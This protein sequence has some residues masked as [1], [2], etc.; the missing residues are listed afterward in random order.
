MSEAQ[1]P[2]PR[3]TAATEGYWR[4]AGEG[5]L[6]VQKCHACGHLQFYPRN[7]CFQCQSDQIGWDPV[8][9]L[10]TIY[11]FTVNY[12]APAP[13]FKTRLPYVVAI[14]ELD[15]GPRLMANILGVSP[16]AVAIGKRVKAVFE[17]ISDG[18]VLPQFQLLD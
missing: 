18:I 10:G 14:I 5:R 15:E 13:F 8:S 16:E 12:R 4:A 2:L 7:L 1:R 6:V 17:K 3:S 9:G 11:T